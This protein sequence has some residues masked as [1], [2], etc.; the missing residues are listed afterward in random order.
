MRVAY[1]GTT[2]SIAL[3]PF[4]ALLREQNVVLLVQ[5]GPTMRTLR[6]RVGSLMEKLRLK[7]GDALRELAREYGVPTMYMHGPHDRRVISALRHLRPDMIC[8]SSF[9]WILPMDL[10]ATARMGGLNL[11][12][13][14][15]PRHRGA[16]PLFWIFHSD[17]RE[18]GVTV[19]RVTADADAGEIVAQERWTLERGTTADQ[20]NEMNAERGAELLRRSVRGM[21]A[22]IIAPFAQDARLATRARKV[23]SPGKM[24]DFESWPAERVWHFLHGVYPYYVEKLSDPSGA[25]L[26]Y[27]EVLG[28]E[29][30]AETEPGVCRVEGDEIIVDCID[31]VVRLRSAPR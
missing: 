17:D 23:R 31:G 30:R 12:S 3:Q 11:H 13:S 1:F 5:P 6:G 22:G 10:V 15:L 27:G 24:V 16:V 19:H 8:I 28:W 20:L 2:G 29:P 21:A 26:R 18:T 4:R 9:R 25:P 7:R 14:L